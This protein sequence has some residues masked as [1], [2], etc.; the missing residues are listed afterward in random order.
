MQ[1]AVTLYR[2]CFLSKRALEE[3]D[4]VL[5]CDGNPQNRLYGWPECMLIC[6]TNKRTAGSVLENCASA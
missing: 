5:F 2:R 6:V 3:T 4:R 1:T